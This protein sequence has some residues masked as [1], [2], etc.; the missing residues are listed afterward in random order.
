MKKL[1]IMT[2]AAAAMAVAVPT[3]HAE[4]AYI[5]SYGTGSICLGHFAGPNT[6]LEVD[7][8][9]ME[10]LPQARLFGSSGNNTTSPL[11]EIYLGNRGDGQ[12]ERFSWECSAVDKTRQAWN[13]DVANVG[14]RRTI[15]FDAS[16]STYTSIPHGAESGVTYQFSKA[17]LN[18]TSSYPLAVFGACSRS[19][20]ASTNDFT[21]KDRPVKMKCYGVRIYESGTLVKNFIPCVKGGKAGLK[22]TINNRFMSSVNVKA[23][24]YGGDILVEKDDPYIS[25]A[26]NTNSIYEANARIPG[27]SIYL[28]T[29]YYFKTTTRLEL[30]YALLTPDWPSDRL[31]GAFLHLLTANG[32]SQKMYVA[33]YGSNASRGDYYVSL[34]GSE[35]ADKIRIYT[36]YDV[37]RMVTVTPKHYSIATAGYTNYSWSTSGGVTSDLLNKP[38]RIAHAADADSGFTPMKI[39]GLKIYESD[40]LV[41]D[42]RPFVTNGVP[43]LIDALNPSDQRFCT[44]YTDSTI[45]TNRMAEAGGDL[46]RDGYTSSAECEAYLEFPASGSGINTGYKVPHNAVIEADFALYLAKSNDSQL[47]IR[48]ESSPYVSLSWVGAYWWKFADTTGGTDG[49]V[50]SASNERLQ[51]IIDSTALTLKRG[52]YIVSTRTKNFTSTITSGSDTLKIGSQNAA[53]RLYGFKVSVGGEVQRDYVPCVTNG[54]AGL[55]ECTTKTFLPLA[56]G[57]VCGK[58]YKGQT[59]EFETVP[60]SMKIERNGTGTLTCFATS[61]QSYEW[62]EDGILIEGATG[63]SLTLNWVRAKAKARKHTYTYSVKP[64][65]TVFNEKVVGEA[66]SAAVEYVPLGM[67]ISVQ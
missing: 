45:K 7:F 29:G 66:A 38:V 11:F 24:G 57:K 58:G 33:V 10:I 25:T 12:G 36:A 16:T 27:T 51:Y 20:G 5:E 1:L 50:P 13:V 28:D 26:V 18:V 8:E 14:E 32:S 49:F 53:M 47:F 30:D 55:Y 37:R 61:A 56:G 4:D 3:A 65:Y 35:S 22:E 2:C 62:Y 23:V 54:V 40:L 19:Y 41:K 64:V 52:D 6:K 34:G 43:G 15:A 42:F 67:I 21:V 31:H 9:L 60:Q 39:Y 44:T 46:G 48:Q 59:D 63:D 17:C